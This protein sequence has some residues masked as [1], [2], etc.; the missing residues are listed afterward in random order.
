VTW[1][2]RI[3]GGLSVG[4]SPSDFNAVELA[5]GALVE[6]EHTSDFMVAV[7]IAMDH[8]TEDKAYYKKLATIESHNP[9][10]RRKKAKKKPV[11]K[12]YGRVTKKQ[13]VNQLVRD[14]FRSIYD[15]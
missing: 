4:K 11:L 6:T 9:K 1:R 7:E 8:L 12:R 13:L 3:P 2:E 15:R 14:Q 10:R 5:R